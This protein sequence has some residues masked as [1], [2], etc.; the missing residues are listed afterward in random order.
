MLPHTHTNNLS[1]RQFAWLVFLSHLSRGAPDGLVPKFINNAE[2]S[3]ATASTPSHALPCL[4]WTEDI[5]P[6]A[7]ISGAKLIIDNQFWIG[8][9]C[10]I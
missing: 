3:G 10:Q 7:I 9:L 5:H 2:D 1:P 6:D 4:S 8:Y